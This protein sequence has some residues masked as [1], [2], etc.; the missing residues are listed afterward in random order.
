MRWSC[1]R[2]RR[3]RRRPVGRGRLRLRL[4]LRFRLCHHHRRLERMRDEADHPLLQPS[5]SQRQEEL[6][7]ELER[8]SKVLVTVS[9]ESQSLENLSWAVTVASRPGDTVVALHLLEDSDSEIRSIEKQYERAR[10]GVLSLLEQCRELCHFRQVTTNVRIVPTFN[11]P[12]AVLLE[13]AAFLDATTLVLSSSD[14]APDLKLS[15]FTECGAQFPGP[16]QGCLVFVA[17]KKRRMSS[18]KL[19]SS[20]VISVQGELLVPDDPQLAEKEQRDESV[21]R[22]L[23]HKGFQCHIT[24]DPVLASSELH[25]CKAA[26]ARLD[27]PSDYSPRGVLEG[28]HSD[29]NDGGAS[30]EEQSSGSSPVFPLL[31]STSSNAA[32]RVEDQRDEEEEEELQASC[33][34]LFRHMKRHNTFPATPG[35]AVQ[36]HRKLIPSFSCSSAHSGMR[37]SSYNSEE[38][39]LSLHSMCAAGDKPPWRCFTYD[40]ILLA[41][42]CFSP[43]NLV[44][45]GG[46]AVVYK[47]TLSDGQ[48]I[49]VK[50]L[51]KGDSEQ[52]KEGGFLTELGIIG[53][54][55]HPNTTPLIGFCVERGLHLVFPFSPHG[56]L[57]SVLHGTKSKALEWSV[58]RKIALGT[59][60]GLQYLHKVCPRRII[61]RDIK[62]SNILLGPDFEPQISDFGLAK[63]LPEQWTHHTVT[64]IEGTFGYLAPEYF[65]HGIVD[66]KT[67][68]F[69]YGVLLLELITGRK[70]IDAMQRNIV[71]WARPYLE[72]CSIQELVDPALAGA[73]DS[74]QLRKLVLVATLCVRQSPLWRPCMSQ[75]LKLLSDETLDQELPTNWSTLVCNATDVDDEY[76]SNEYHTDM[77]RHRALA[78]GT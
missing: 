27:I 75:V 30:P 37:F 41:T 35:S 38:A 44:G 16:P 63:W 72:S 61:H 7:L 56:S 67:D 54:V 20:G 52:H 58:R 1:Y 3:R 48:L 51:T 2:C 14:V 15:G 6:E 17:Q 22:L 33:L 68:I 25:C 46:Y 71:V 21:Q 73:Y 24:T 69:A 77:N 57:A 9:L 50:K 8:H 36:R 23:P 26:H 55:T 49:A 59:A 29:S 39:E 31:V 74:N 78:L 34:N 66:E 12:K 64:P 45:K 40:E 43:D 5:E 60:R 42:S 18:K 11:G 10:A 19:T 62:A 53:H 76:T 13:Q 65:M 47:G 70:P 28:P 4:R 32:G